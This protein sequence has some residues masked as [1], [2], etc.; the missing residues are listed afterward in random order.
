MDDV[1]DVLVTDSEEV[2][3]G[4]T[5]VVRPSLEMMVNLTVLTGGTGGAVVVVDSLFLACSFSWQTEQIQ[6]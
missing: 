1:T 6:S 4:I 5:V 3:N 2:L